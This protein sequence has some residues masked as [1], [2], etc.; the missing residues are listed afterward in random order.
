MFKPKIKIPTNFYLVT[1]VSFL[2][3][4]LFFDS[5]DFYSQYQLRKKVK[6][7]EE[8]KIYYKDQIEEVETDREALLKDADKLEKLAREKYYMKK[9]NEDVFVIVEE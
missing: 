8:E 3:W 5:N 6:A 1:G 9:D 2:V 4:M 7:L